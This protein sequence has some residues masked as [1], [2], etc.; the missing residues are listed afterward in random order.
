MGQT[1]T[2]CEEVVL[3]RWL[4]SAPPANVCHSLVLLDPGLT[5]EHGS[6]TSRKEQNDADIDEDN[7]C[8]GLGNI[9]L[10]M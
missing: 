3:V 2:G 1:P 6:E 8:G 5:A 9:S 7:R 4:A 10:L